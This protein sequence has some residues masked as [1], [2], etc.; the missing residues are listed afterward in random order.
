MRLKKT[1]TGIEPATFDLTYRKDHSESQQSGIDGHTA[2]TDK[3]KSFPTGPFDKDQ[4]NNSHKHVDTS[5]AEGSVGCFFVAEAAHAEDFTREEHNL[6]K[7]ETTIIYFY[8]FN[9]VI[10]KCFLGY[11]MFEIL[12][13]Y[14]VHSVR[15]RIFFYL[16]QKKRC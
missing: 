8:Y 13:L 5:H 7:K 2:E 1:V 12:D 10:S 15:I 16:K 6:K 4:R 9:L 14:I 3:E 11:K